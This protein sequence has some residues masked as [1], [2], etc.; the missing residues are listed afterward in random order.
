MHSLQPNFDLKTMIFAMIHID[1]SSDCT[2]VGGLKW[3]ASPTVRFWLEFGRLEKF[4]FRVHHT[5]FVIRVAADIE[6]EKTKER[7]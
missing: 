3:F 5:K 2:G 6:R 1:S 7:N 4:T